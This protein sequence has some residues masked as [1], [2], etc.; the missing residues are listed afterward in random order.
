MTR[1]PRGRSLSVAL[2]AVL[3]A[4]LATTTLPPLAVQ[5]SA[6]TDAE[7]LAVD[8]V[9]A[10]RVSAG[11]VPLRRY[12]KLAAIAGTRAARMRDANTLSHTVGGSIT[13]QFAS[14]GVTWYSYGETIGY[15]YASWASGAARDLVRLWMA[16]PAHRALLMSSKSNYIGVGLAYRS[17]NGRTYGS[18][19][20]TESPDRNGARSWVTKTAITGG[21]DITW[22]WSGADL[23]LQT[24]TAG[25]RDYDVQ[26]RVGYG[27]WHTVY[28]DTT[29][30]SL[31]LWNRTHG[32][33]YGVRV[34]ATDRRGNI[35]AWTAEKRVKLP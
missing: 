26:Y 33:T 31:T 25:L 22:T 6:E 17:S 23:R 28:N 7:S 11:L 21:N 19:V 2:S 14:A 15:S 18:I 8:L 29:R 30:T 27:S 4:V 10:Q 34:R 24:H 32:T 1:R 12:Y 13:T 35:G 9:N 3:L 5:A 16:S 20:M